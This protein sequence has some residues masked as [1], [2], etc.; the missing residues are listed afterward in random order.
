MSDKG[1]PNCDLLQRDIVPG[2]LVQYLVNKCLQILVLLFL[3]LFPLCQIY[4]GFNHIFI[5]KRSVT[6]QLLVNAFLPSH[7][8][9][10]DRLRQSK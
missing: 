3:C 10:I 7:C 8:L 2:A 6:L 9:R 5:F 1:C 4:H